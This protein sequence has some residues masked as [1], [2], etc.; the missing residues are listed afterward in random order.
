MSDEELT[1]AM[2]E[3]QDV[4]RCRCDEAYRDRGLKDPY[5]EC[6]SAEAVKIVAS[7]IKALTEQLSAARK[8]AEEAEAYAEEVEKELNTCRMAQAVM[9]NTVADL[10]AKLAKAVE[11][12]QW[13]AM[14]GDGDVAL[15]T[16]AEIKGERHE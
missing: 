8:D 10:E 11:A 12:L 4:V 2:A 13:C 7:R 6:D 1:L 14:Y 9:D 3:L 16:L 15:A 5:C